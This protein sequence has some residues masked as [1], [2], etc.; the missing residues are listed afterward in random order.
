MKCPKCEERMDRDTFID[1]AV[2]HREQDFFVCHDCEVRIDKDS[3]DASCY[4]NLTPKD[5]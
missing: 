3:I 1:Y 2:D 5:E 4:E